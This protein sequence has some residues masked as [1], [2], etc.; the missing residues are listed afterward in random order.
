MSAENVLRQNPILFVDSLNLVARIKQLI[1]NSWKSF[2]SNLPLFIKKQSRY[3]IDK[4]Y[5]VL[6]SFL[7][8]ASLISHP[9]IFYM[10]EISTDRTCG[11]IWASEKSDESI[12]KILCGSFRR[13]RPYWRF[14]LGTFCEE[15]M[16]WKDAEGIGAFVET[17]LEFWGIYLWN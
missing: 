15:S 7:Q 3:V 14:L 12:M 17:R 5:V 11:L 4:Q 8:A 16:I 10:K 9:N 6:I 2:I 1:P 13:I